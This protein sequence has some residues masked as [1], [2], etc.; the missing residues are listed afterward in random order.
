MPVLP[1]EGCPAG[2]PGGAVPVGGLS[3][4]L[5]DKQS[6][7]V[8]SAGGALAAVRAAGIGGDVAADQGEHGGERDQA[9]ID[10]GLRRRGRRIAAV[11][12][13]ISSSAQASCRARAG[14]RPRRGAAGA[15]NGFL[16]VQ[17]RARRSSPSRSS[18]N[19]GPAAACAS[20]PPASAGPASSPC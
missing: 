4:D 1:L 14:E 8:V 15:L 5:V 16:Q 13:W 12:L 11:M 9:R 10:P 2:G 17:E 6:D 19:P 3:E 20:R 7:G 18:Q